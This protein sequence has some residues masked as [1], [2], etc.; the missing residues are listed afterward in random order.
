[1]KVPP[2]A[3]MERVLIGQEWVGSIVQSKQAQRGPSLTCVFGRRLLK[4]DMV[5][6]ACPMVQCSRPLLW[7]GGDEVILFLIV[8]QVETW[9]TPEKLSSEISGASGKSLWRALNNPCV[10]CF[11]KLL[12]SIWGFFKTNWRNDNDQAEESHS[13]THLRVV[14]L[15]LL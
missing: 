13:H 12:F 9:L 14:S 8:D 4:W 10:V 3:I 11:V 1:M 5:H 7:Y 6:N 15:Y 2:Q